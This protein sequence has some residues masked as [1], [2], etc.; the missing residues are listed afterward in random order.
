MNSTPMDIDHMLLDAIV[1][2]PNEIP[3]TQYNPA[4]TRK[5][6]PFFPLLTNIPILIE[7]VCIVCNDRIDNNGI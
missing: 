4:P 5:V 6:K 3:L 7:K 1:R 2:L